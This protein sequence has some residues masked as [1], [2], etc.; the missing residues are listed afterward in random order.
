MNPDD[1]IDD[2]I[3]EWHEGD[4]DM[5]LHQFLGMTWGEYT[6]WVNQSG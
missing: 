5:P 3:D 1:D 4:Y 6:T 2:L